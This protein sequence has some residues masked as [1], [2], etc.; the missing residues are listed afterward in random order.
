MRAIDRLV[1]E[2]LERWKLP[3][4]RLS[5]EERDSWARTAGEVILKAPETQTLF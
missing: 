4:E 2:L 5:A 1:D 3:C